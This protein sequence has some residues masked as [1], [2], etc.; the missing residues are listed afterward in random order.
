MT[1]TRISK[2]TRLWPVALVL[3][4]TDC[5]TSQT[6]LKVSASR[7]ARVGVVS[8]VEPQLTNT[9]VGFTVF[10]SFNKR[11]VNDWGL[12]RAALSD[13]TALLHQDGYEVVSVS[14]D[15]NL[16]RGIREENDWSDLNYSG[17]DKNWSATYQKLMADNRL[18]ALVI[19]REEIMH[20]GK[21]GRYDYHGFGIFSGSRAEL[22][23][24]VAADVISGD[25]PHRSIASCI[26]APL[27]DKKR[28]PVED[29]GDIKI[30]DILWAKPEL[31]S[32]LKKKLEFD[33]ASSGLL[34]TNAACPGFSPATK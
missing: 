17:L 12:D 9:H 30:D 13:V 20:G 4:L 16:V 3:V 26:A 14:I 34:N 24:S 19:L 7:G 15:D 22:F 28:V 27:F 29:F 25:P 5:A 18:S 10:T 1:I 33:L 32:L 8:V 21:D 2:L 23:V 11:L 6:F 31:E